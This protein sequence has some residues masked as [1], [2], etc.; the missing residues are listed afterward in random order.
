MTRYAVDRKTGKL[1]QIEEAVAPVMMQP[2]HDPITER[3][4]AALEEQVSK[5]HGLPWGHLAFVLSFGA[6]GGLADVTIIGYSR[7]FADLAF[8]ILGTV[9]LAEV[10]TR[11]RSVV[12]EIAQSYAYHRERVAL[13]D[14][15]LER[16]KQQQA[17]IRTRER[18][19]MAEASA[20]EA[21]AVMRAA[22]AGQERRANPAEV[23]RQHRN[24]ER[25]A[26]MLDETYENYGN[27]WQGNQPFAK[28][29]IGPWYDLLVRIG[30]VVPKGSQPQWNW[31]FAETADQALAK[32]LHLVPEIATIEPPTG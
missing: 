7:D 3:A 12:I 31:D 25:L 29:R 23:N 9:V 20:A 21:A 30:A 18:R 10:A 2:T 19:L 8:V 11:L 27:K 24:R 22:E 28:R 15:R 6:L 5:R 4:L 1:I 32:I 14:I 16:W 26:L 13:A 17:T